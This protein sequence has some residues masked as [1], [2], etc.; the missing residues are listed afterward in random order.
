[1]TSTW[2]ST[3]CSGMAGASSASSSV[4]DKSSMVG[5]RGSRGD[6]SSATSFAG[7]SAASMSSAHTQRRR[8]LGIL[9]TPTTYHM[10]PTARLLRLL[11]GA[12]EF[13]PWG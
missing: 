12:A 11:C 5:R 13:G 3:D 2:T 7:G 10:C 4:D 9:A 8:W 6:G 1:M